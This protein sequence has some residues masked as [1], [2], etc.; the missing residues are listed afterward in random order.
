MPNFPGVKER[1]APGCRVGF[2]GVKA[3]PRARK[4][5]IALCFVRQRR[6]HAR[7]ELPEIVGACA[8]ADGVTLETTCEE[9]G[10]R[11][12]AVPGRSTQRHD[13]RFGRHETRHKARPR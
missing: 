6:E 13:A 1:S 12:F 7:G 11:R 2:A 5:A 8:I 4:F 10:E 3:Q 9:P